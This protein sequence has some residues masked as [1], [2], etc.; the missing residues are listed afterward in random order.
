MYSRTQRQVVKVISLIL[1]ILT[2][3]VRMLFSLLCHRLYFSMSAFIAFTILYWHS[4]V[5]TLL[6]KLFTL[7]YLSITSYLSFLLELLGPQQDK[8]NTHRETPWGQTNGGLFVK[9][10]VW[11][12]KSCLQTHKRWKGD[13][14]VHKSRLVGCGGI[15]PGK[16]T[17]YIS[18]HFQ[19]R[20]KEKDNIHIRQSIYWNQYS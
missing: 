6:Y 20:I 15:L 16:K 19:H 1:W 11:Q 7:I 17:K 8:G 14:F 10:K 18:M 13:M 4:A 9:H 3:S 2:E 12:L 5:Q